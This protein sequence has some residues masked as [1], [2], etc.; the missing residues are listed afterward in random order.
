MGSVDAIVASK[1]GVAARAAGHQVAWRNAP[2]ADTARDGGRELGELEV[3]LSLSDGRL[4]RLDGGTRNPL[5]LDPLVERL[6]RDD[7]AAREALAALQVALREGEIGARL[8]E[9]RLGLVERRLEGAAIDR[10]QGLALAHH[11]AVLEV[12]GVEIAGHARAHLDIVDGDEAPDILVMIGNELL[13]R[14]RDGHLR[15]RRSGSRALGLRL[16]VSAAGEGRGERSNQT[17]G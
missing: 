3:E 5:G 4:L 10:E 1:R 7:G 9:S 8:R 16:A 12:D 11:L 2:V 6:L 13:D 14:L 15:R 17:R